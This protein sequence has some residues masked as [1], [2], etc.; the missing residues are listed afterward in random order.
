MGYIETCQLHLTGQEMTGND[1]A[2]PTKSCL[3]ISYRT[4]YHTTR[5]TPVLVYLLQI[6][7][8]MELYE[9]HKL[10]G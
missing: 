2:R 1:T 7:F 6:Q 10:I 9:N 3:V 5:G 8:A 4:A